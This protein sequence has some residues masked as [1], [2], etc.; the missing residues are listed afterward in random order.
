MSSLHLLLV[1]LVVWMGI[2]SVRKS[3]A[4]FSVTTCLMYFLPLLDSAGGSPQSLQTPKQFFFTQ[5]SLFTRDAGLIRLLLHQSRK[6]LPQQ[7]RRDCDGLYYAQSH[8]QRNET[9]PD[10]VVL[11]IL[12]EARLLL[13]ALLQD[14]GVAWA[15]LQEGA[16]PHHRKG[17]RVE[18]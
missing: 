9:A 4:F 15:A 11:T 14:L 18:E 2:G 16:T 1:W 3:L 17:S 5:N 6:L 12:F 10:N 7:Q 8:I 13:Q